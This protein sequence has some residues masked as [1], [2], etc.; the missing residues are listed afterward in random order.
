MW[1]YLS[2]EDSANVTVKVNGTN[3]VRTYAIPANTVRVSDFM[4]TSGLVDARLTDEGL[5]NKGISIESDVP[6]VAYAHISDGANSGA[7]MLLPTGV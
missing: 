7:G 1:L 3:W 2:A 6:I 5:F 4:P